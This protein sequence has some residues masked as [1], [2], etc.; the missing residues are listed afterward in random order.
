M[1]KLFL[2][3]KIRLTMGQGG[4]RRKGPKKFKDRGKKVRGVGPLRGGGGGET[5]CRAVGT[6]GGNLKVGK[7]LFRLKGKKY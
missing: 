2:Q 1:N 5:K 7:K 4:R 6:T 3:V